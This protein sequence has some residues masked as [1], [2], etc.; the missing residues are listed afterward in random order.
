[1]I[2]ISLLVL[3]ISSAALSAAPAAEESYPPDIQR[4]IAR[5]K[6]IVALPENDHPPFFWFDAKKNR[7]LALPHGQMTRWPYC[8]A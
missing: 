1:M 6:L 5:K 8:E 4:I 3:A 2:R 7:R